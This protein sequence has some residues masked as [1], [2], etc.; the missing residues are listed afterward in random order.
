MIAIRRSI[1]PANT[2]A[3]NTS[4]ANTSGQY[5]RGQYQRRAR[6]FGRIGSIRAKPADLFDTVDRARHLLCGPR[7]QL[8]RLLSRHAHATH[9]CDGS[10]AHSRRRCQ[11]SRHAHEVWCEGVRQGGRQRPSVDKAGRV[12]SGGRVLVSCRVVSCRVV[13]RSRRV[14]SGGWVTHASS[15]HLAA[16]VGGVRAAHAGGR[17][18]D[19]R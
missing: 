16:S 8:A 18:R 17:H 7:L 4:A 13:S 11:R 14:V 6:S 12:G 19:S 15:R 3:A 1:P 2:S 5:Q 10:S 9:A